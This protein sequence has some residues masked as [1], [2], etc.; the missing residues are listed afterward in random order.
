MMVRVFAGLII[1]QASISF[2]QP[3]LTGTVIMPFVLDGKIVIV[4]E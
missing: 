4:L 1:D 2:S 3:A